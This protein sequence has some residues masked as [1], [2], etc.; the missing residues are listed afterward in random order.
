[1]TNP[2]TRRQ[3]L[4]DA[5]RSSGATIA[6]VLIPARSDVEDAADR[7]EIRVKNARRSLQDLGADEPLLDTVESSL[8][9][10]DHADAPSLALVATADEVIIADAMLRPVDK[11]FV[12]LGPTPTLLPLLA[13]TQ[14]DIGHVAVLIDREG[15]DL[16]FR[17][18]LGTPVS[19]AEV[20]GD[21]EHIHRGHPGGWSQ[22]RFQQIAENT[23]EQNAKLVVDAVDD[24]GFDAEIVVVGGDQRA[25]GFFS[26]HVPPRL[27]ELVVVD[28]SRAA[29]PDAFLDNADVAVR[30]VAADRLTS[31]IERFG[32]AL[33]QGQAVE[34]E[35]ALVQ[36]GRGLVDHL[37]VADDTQADDR[38]YQWFDFSVPLV[39]DEGSGSRAPATDGAVA[40]AEATGAA[41]TVVPSSVVKRSMVAT[42]RT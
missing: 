5:Y 3:Q 9:S 31:A 22:R 28:G 10:F 11:L 30:T 40:L 7:Y 38:W 1:M 25:V 18:D 26:D 6:T 21:T 32:D 12:A 14:N 33:G 20:S 23:W 13:A 27:G 17:D 37:Y 8:R 36:L 42:L 16:W 4:L 41:V 15:A 29:G 35:E 24:E 2:S 19:T 39:A 34:G